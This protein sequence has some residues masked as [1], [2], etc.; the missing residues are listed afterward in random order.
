MAK[1]TVRDLT[2]SGQR[3][4]VRVD[5]NVPIEEK[6]GRVV[7]NDVTRIRETLPTLKLLI[8]KGSRIV[9]AAHLGR[10]DGRREPALSLRPVADKLAD[11]LGRPV[12]FVD[13][14]VGEKAEAAAKA[15]K[16]G[17]LLLLE[18][19]RFHREEEENDPVFAAR[20]S[21][22]AD[23]YVNDAF[24]AAHRAHASTCGV[25]RIISAWGGRCAAGLLMERELQF[26][27]DELERP[28]R[29]F[30]VILG[31]AKVS[32]KIKVIDRLIDKADTILIGGAMAYTFKLAHGRKTGKSLVEPE[33]LQTALDAE[34]K[35]KERN[36]QFELPTDNVISELKATGKLNKKGKPIQ[37]PVNPRVNADP[38]IPADC[39]G[40]DIG[41]ATAARFAELI[42]SA[43]TIL[44]NGPMG[45]FEDPRFG[46]GTLAVAKAV[47]AATANGAK[48]IIGGGDSVKAI[49]KAKLG[50][51]VS[52]MSTGGGASLEFLEGTPLPGV[53]CLDDR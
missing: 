42:Q 44:W 5:Y 4:L 33:H 2:V 21:L 28:A 20:L 41:P 31:G 40:F 11:L 3:V 50:D 49:N 30:V 6:D 19:V 8:E 32:D 24:G 38:D 26:L 45:M 12:Q 25:A 36:V 35:A 18:N 14:C 53:T 7:I 27:G 17:E 37:E 43:K 34:A 51:K 47:A 46:E 15:L 22:L 52:F 9:L 13:Q 48:S 39:E 1:L 10:P 16:D 29:P 23:A